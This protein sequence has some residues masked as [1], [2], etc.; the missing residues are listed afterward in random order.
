DMEVAEAEIVIQLGRC[1]VRPDF[2]SQRALAD[3]GYRYD[4][5]RRAYRHGA[6]ERLIVVRIR[7]PGI[8]G[9]IQHRIA[10]AR[11]KSAKS[12]RSEIR[13]SGSGKWKDVGTAGLLG[14]RHG[15]GEHE[16][17]IFAR[18]PQSLG[19]QAGVI[20]TRAF[21]RIDLTGALLGDAREA[22]RQNV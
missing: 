6:S 17:Q 16:A 4:V 12:R 18:M 8:S 7:M 11:I 20:V 2:R 1:V 22:N 14:I 3:A 13:D 9:L 15:G 21:K 19:A 5:N 10:A